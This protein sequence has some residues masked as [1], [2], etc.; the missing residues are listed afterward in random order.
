MYTNCKSLESRKI[1]LSDG[2]HY[3]YRNLFIYMRF[4]IA[5][6]FSGGASSE[7]SERSGG[8]GDFGVIFQSEGVPN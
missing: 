1:V 2:I 8:G 4:S 3:I 5:V 7:K 6:W